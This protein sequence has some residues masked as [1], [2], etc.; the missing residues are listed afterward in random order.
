MGPRL[1][2]DDTVVTA[3]YLYC[4][5]NATNRNSPSALETSSRMDFLPSF[6]NWSTRFFTSAALDTAS[7]ATSTITSPALSRFSA[8]SDEESTL[9]MTTP[10]TL[11]L[12]L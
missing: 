9:V 7:C 4:T 1:R 3:Q 8:A 5:L 11:S 10:L 2:E 6:F 12:I